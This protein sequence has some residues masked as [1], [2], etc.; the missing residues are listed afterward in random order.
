MRKHPS[1]MMAVLAILMLILAACTS[2]GGESPS[3]AAE[4]Q[5]A[6]SDGSEPSASQAAESEPAGSTAESEAP[7]A[8]E[9][10]TGLAACGEP[11]SGDAF[12]IG[13][14]TDVGSLEDKS[15]NEG[16][17]C[18]TIAGATAVGGTADVIVT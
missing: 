2:D 11:E 10:P 5:P 3:D 6:T 4:S 13:G 7:S 9:A 18:G 12:L 17:W 15:F 8:S 1:S 14:V 16:G